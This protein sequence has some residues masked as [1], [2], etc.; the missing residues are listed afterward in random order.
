MLSI[1]NIQF[2]RDRFEKVNNYYGKKGLSPQLSLLRIEE[3]LV[4]GQGLYE[5][6]IRKENLSPVERNLKRN[7]LFVTIAMGI[8]TR[9]ENPSKPNISVPNFSPIMGQVYDNSGTKTILSEGFETSDI[10]AL[11]NGSLRITTGTTVNFEDMPTALFLQQ[12]SDDIT[13]TSTSNA[14]FKANEIRSK[15]FDFE[16]Q[17]KTMSEEMTF[18]GTQDHKISVNF[19]TFAGAKYGAVQAGTSASPTTNYKTKIIFLA[20]GFRVLGGTEQEYKMDEKHNPYSIC[21]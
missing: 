20:L 19:P 14:A 12:Q 8:A 11:Y 21:I 10:M 5:F 7:D 3:D 15:I 9:I 6:N 1:S 18:A 4:D 17:L 16:S 2:V 13:K